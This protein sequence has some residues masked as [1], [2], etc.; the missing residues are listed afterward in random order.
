MA[1]RGERRRRR[2]TMETI[3]DKLK[4]LGICWRCAGVALPGKAICLPCKVEM[5]YYP[6]QWKETT[7]CHDY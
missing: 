4:R 3:G 5:S 2:E 6:K 7:P 1:R